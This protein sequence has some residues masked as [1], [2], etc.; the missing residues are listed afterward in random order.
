MYIYACHSEKM[1]QDRQGF[2]NLN[3]NTTVDIND[4]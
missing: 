3:E 4:D 1:N 2:S